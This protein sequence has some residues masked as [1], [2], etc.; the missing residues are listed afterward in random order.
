MLA[1]RTAL[2]AATLLLAA[3]ASGP[4]VIDS[5][6]STDAAAAP[7]A[8]LLRQV[9]YRFEAAPAVAGQPDPHKIQA[10]AEQALQRVGA[11]RDEANA[12][13][14]VQASARVDAYWADDYWGGAS[15]TRLSLGLGVG[16]GWHGGGIGLGFGWPF[17]SN[18]VPAYNSEVSLVMRELASGAIIYSTQARHNGPWHDTDAVLGALFVAALEGYPQPAQRVRRVQVPVQAAQKDPADGEP[19]ASDS[20]TQAN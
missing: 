16:S 8:D 12:R 17:W 7:G 9:H 5:Q 15:N 1:L 20:D 14:S 10:L 2:I 4:R 11:V 6:V 18:S 19:A 3:C 13:V